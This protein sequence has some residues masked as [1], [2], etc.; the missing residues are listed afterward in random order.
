MTEE[1]SKRPFRI[2]V[3]ERGTVDSSQN[4]T[5]I[6]T[7]EGTTTIIWIIPEGKDVKEG[8]LVCELDSSM[9]MDKEKQQQIL[10]TQADADLKRARE[11]VEIQKTQ[12]ESNTS[13]AELAVELSKLDLKKFKDGDAVQEEARIQSE[14]TLAQEKLNQARGNHEFTKQIAKKGYKTLNAVETLRIAVKDA[15]LKLAIA[16]GELTVQVDY[17]YKRTI[18]ELDEKAKETVRELVRVK[19]AGIASLAQYEADLKARTLTNDVE[20]GKLEKLEKQIAACKLTAPQQG[21]VIYASQQSRR[22]EPVVIEEGA[23]VRERQAI[24]KLPDFSQMKV[25]ARIHE[26]KISQIREGLSVVIQVDALPNEVYHG[27]LE[28]VSDVPIPGSWPNYD[29]KEYEAEIRITAE[30]EER[31]HE[32][33]PGMTAGLEI[34][35]D[36]GD[37]DVLQ[38]PIQAVVSVGDKFVSYVLTLDG[39]VL[40][41][42]ELGRTNDTAVEILSG[43]EAGERVILNPKTHLAEE[44]SDLEAKYGATKPK[45]NGELAEAP[46]DPK[47]LPGRKPPRAKKKAGD[48]DRKVTPKAQEAKRNPIQPSGKSRPKGARQPKKAAP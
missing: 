34:V 36:E 20:K 7:V 29:L 11:N 19:R 44:L 43:L 23:T 35:V 15:E 40:R 45:A 22:S 31:I 32:L 3:T 26:S 46:F 1:V 25:D 16:Q 8:E 41:D 9:L 10:V 37:E 33:K 18:R 28:H 17:T 4:S 14:I 21:K 13:A 2:A 12:N 42:V 48:G 39:P 6:N 38:T 47:T 5:L 30:D 24:I 27:I